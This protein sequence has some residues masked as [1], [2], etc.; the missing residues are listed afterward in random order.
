MNANNEN[1]LL[2]NLPNF[3]EMAEFLHL[4]SV[5]LDHGRYEFI[6]F[7]NREMEIVL[8]DDVEE[9]NC[10]AIGSI[11]PP[12]QQMLEFL[13]LCHTLKKEGSSVTAILPYLAYMRQD[14]NEL[15]A[16]WGAKWVASLIKASG[17]DEL[18]TLDI[19]SRLAMNLFDIPI[20][21][22]SPSGIFADEIK[23][24]GFLDAT[25]VAPDEGAIER[26]ENVRDALGKKEDISYFKKERKES[27][28]SSVFYGTVGKRAIIID[29]ILDTG[30]TLIK[31]CE[32]LR[33]EGAEEIVIMVTHGLFTG[34]LWKQLFDLNVKRIYITDTLPQNRLRED[35][36]ITVLSSTHLIKEY[37]ADQE[38]KL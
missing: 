19:H 36:K 31:S 22:L 2:F 1:L 33:K 4:N 34:E 12:E 23:T 3:N 7:P 30:N 9:R 6:H 8:E 37:I 21:S 27:L 18:I 24:L 38:W 25:L 11:S 14:K 5:F 28:V 26:C 10:L 17:I 20:V 32:I 15:L 16:S 29:D 13:M 35:D